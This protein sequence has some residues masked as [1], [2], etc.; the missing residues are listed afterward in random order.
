MLIPSAFI[1]HG[2]TPIQRGET[3]FSFTHAFI[4]H[5][6][7]PIQHG[8]TCFSFTQYAAGTLFHWVKYGFHTAKFILAS[9]GGQSWRPCMME[10]QDLGGD[11]PWTYFQ[12][13]R[14]SS[15][16]C[17]RLGVWQIN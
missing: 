17:S 14:S 13:M 3:C 11:G 15:L 7:T 5:G 8:K 16:S 1:N 4:D 2:N 10:F 12:N 9:M 6:N